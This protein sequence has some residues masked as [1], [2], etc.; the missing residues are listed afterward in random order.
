MKKQTAIEKRIAELEWKIRDIRDEIDMLEKMDMYPTAEEKIL[1][2][3]L[4]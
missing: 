4:P 1:T 2:E 3:Q